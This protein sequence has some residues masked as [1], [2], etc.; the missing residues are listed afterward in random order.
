MKKQRKVT[1]EGEKKNEERYNKTYKKKGTYC[2]AL[3]NPSDRNTPVWMK[4]SLNYLFT[5]TSTE[6]TRFLNNWL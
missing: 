1:K 3:Q 4:L 2:R 5:T 6:I